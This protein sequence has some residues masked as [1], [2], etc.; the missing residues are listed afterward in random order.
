MPRKQVPPVCLE[1]T[2]SRNPHCLA[3]LGEERVD[4][5]PGA[6]AACHGANASPRF[7]TTDSIGGADRDRTDDLLNAIQGAWVCWSLFWFDSVP[8]L[9]VR[10]ATV[11][12]GLSRGDCYVIAEG[13]GSESRGVG[14]HLVS[15][16]RV[17]DLIDSP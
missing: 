14:R 6:L 7:L 8:F 5:P 2:S 10:L 12:C 9:L 15:S 4:D 11:C 13:C 1:P 16:A 3:G 17:A